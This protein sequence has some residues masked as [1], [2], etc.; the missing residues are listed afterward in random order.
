M[1]NKRYNVSIMAA[2]VF[3]LTVLFIPVGDAFAQTQLPIFADDIVASITDGDTT[4]IAPVSLR[5]ELEQELNAQ[6]SVGTLGEVIDSL[7]A[8]STG[9][10]LRFEGG[11]PAGDAVTDLDT[12]GYDESTDI[13]DPALPS[14]GFATLLHD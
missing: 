4:W 7:P 1:Q 3:A 11:W 10:T 2:A 6:A 12:L 14:A 9:R 5:T 13:Q 8:A